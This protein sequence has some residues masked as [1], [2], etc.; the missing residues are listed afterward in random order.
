MYVRIKNEQTPI[1]SQFKAMETI[2]WK[3]FMLEG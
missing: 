3:K 2:S 1:R